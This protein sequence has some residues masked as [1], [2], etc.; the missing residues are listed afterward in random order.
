MDLKNTKT[1]KNLLAAFAGESQAANKYEFFASQAK[2]DGYEQIANIF[3]ETEKNERAHAK[4]WF[5]LL[6][7]GQIKNTPENLKDAAAGENYEWTDMYKKFAEEAENEGFSEI[8]DLFRK[9]AEIEKEHEQRYLALLN[10][11]NS[12]KVFERENE[13]VWICLNCGHIH[14]GNQAPE[15]CPV[16]SHPKAYFQLKQQNY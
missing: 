11:I 1:E 9:V 16:C 6:N 14:Y 4:I 13:T 7:G 3:L 12:N 10:N 5:K 8:A 15:K 2:K